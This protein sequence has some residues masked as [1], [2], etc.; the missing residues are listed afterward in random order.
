MPP[1]SSEADKE[2][3]YFIFAVLHEIAHAVLKH[4]P[5]DELKYQD[6][7]SQEHEADRH[8][9]EWFNSHVSENI[10][11]G[12]TPLNID[13]VRETQAEYHKK[14]EPVLNHGSQ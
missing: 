12:L 5:P 14:L 7:E 9:L 4:S 3:R 8:A 1:G 11:I 13:E 10:D 2:W 6:N